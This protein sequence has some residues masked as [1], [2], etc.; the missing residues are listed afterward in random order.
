MTTYRD[1]VRA[2]EASD[3]SRLNRLCVAALSRT[4]RLESEDLVKLLRT[5]RRAFRLPRRPQSDAESECY[6][7]LLSIASTE[8]RLARIID[9]VIAGF[10]SAHA[11]DD[12]DLTEILLRAEKITSGPRQDDYER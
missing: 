2:Y 6:K 3:D 1:A 7:C 10:S 9:D 12:G 11:I 8:I 5:A 4:T